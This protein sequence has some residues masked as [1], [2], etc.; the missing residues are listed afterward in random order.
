[1]R[2][3]T[4]A[5]RHAA[6]PESAIYER[7]A[8]DEGRRSQVADTEASV[9]DIQDGHHRALS[10]AESSVEEALIG[11]GSRVRRVEDITEALRGTRVSPLTVSDLNK[12][13]YGTTRRAQPADRRRASLCL[14][15]RHRAQAQ[16]GRRG[17]QRLARFPRAVRY[18]LACLSHRG[19][20]KSTI[21]MIFLPLWRFVAA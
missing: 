15:R 8:A 4:S 17:S 21:A 20:Q 6:I 7:K 16:L 14:P 9:A 2:N 1:M 3:V 13:I 12:Q 18:A 11:P 19:S 5:A 10:S